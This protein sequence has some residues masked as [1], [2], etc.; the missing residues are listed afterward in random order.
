[1]VDFNERFNNFA[2]DIR[3]DLLEHSQNDTYC[4]Y[5]DASKLR[6]KFDKN[7]NGLSLLHINIRSIIFQASTSI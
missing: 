5:Y 2:F 6:V 1:M 3:T 4:H 7:K